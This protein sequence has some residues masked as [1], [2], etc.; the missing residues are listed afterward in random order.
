MRQCPH[1]GGSGLQ[2]TACPRCGT[3]PAQTQPNPRA[4]APADDAPWTVVA[5]F[6]NAAEA[7]YFANE[8]DF[9]LGFEPRLDCRDDFDAVHHHWRSGFV[10]SVPEHEADRARAALRALLDSDSPPPH[11]GDELPL[12]DAV[13]LRF[14]RSTTVASASTL[15]GSAIKWGPLFL[16][17]A[18][19][20]LMIWHGRKPQ[21]HRPA[22][23]P[24]DRL[25]I[26]LRDAPG[27]YDAVW[28]Q[29]ADGVRRQLCF[30]G[31]DADAFLREDL[32]GDGVFER[33]FSLR[34]G[35]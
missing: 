9:L 10:L 29:S 16:T 18:A 35:D 4:S 33:E 1:C 32:D 31:P 22:V 20:S 26:P 6:A 30:P 14:E 8:L 2:D 28:I 13:P 15:P 19:G 27:L 7:G 34:V 3:D 21:L 5:R 11:R 24:R 25:R 12:A 17:L 23:D